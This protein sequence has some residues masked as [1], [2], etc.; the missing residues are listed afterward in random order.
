MKNHLPLFGACALGTG[1]LVICLIYSWDIFLEI[2]EIQKEF[3]FEM[4]SFRIMTVEIS[5]QLNDISQPIK[6]K[7]N[8]ARRTKKQSYYQQSSY[9]PSL[10]VEEAKPPSFTPPPE[11]VCNCVAPEENPCPRGPP[12]S[13]GLRGEPGVDGKNGIP[14]RPGLKAENVEANQQDFGRCFSCPAGEPGAPGSRG[15][16][17]TR[18]P[19]GQRGLS[20]TPGSDG[21]PG[22][23]GESGPPGPTGEVGKS[24]PQGKPGKSTKRYVGL[25]GKKGLQGNPGIYGPPGEKG[26]TGYTGEVGSLG[27]QGPPG[28]RGPKGFDGIPG[29]QGAPGTPGPDALYCHCPP[30]NYGNF[31]ASYPRRSRS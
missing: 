20:G 17:G 5:S 9:F 16:P 31:E 19:R 23:P 24:G 4:D 6:Q 25:R 26:N 12:G 22:S 13:K 11:A 1:A 3:D 7:L 2:N 18:G 28:I 21:P 15:R 10:G 14:G 8:E 29:D 30:R 27:P